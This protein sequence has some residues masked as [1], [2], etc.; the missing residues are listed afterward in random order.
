MPDFV[1]QYVELDD[2]GSA[3]CPFHDDEHPSFQV[4]AQGNYWSCHAGCGGGSI[5]DFW[6][7]MRAQR[8]EDAS[9]K[10]TVAELRAMLLV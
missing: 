7:K 3:T 6:Q 2:R 8:G 10:A 9:F 5:I 4:N 1:G